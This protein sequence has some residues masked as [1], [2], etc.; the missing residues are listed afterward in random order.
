[1][2]DLLIVTFIVLALGGLYS[3]VRSAMGLRHEYVIYEYEAGL[4]FKI[5][6]HARS[7]Q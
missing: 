1:M 6:P 2:S 7:T 5:C 3:L 4:L